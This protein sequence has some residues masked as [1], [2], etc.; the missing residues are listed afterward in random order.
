MDGDRAPLAE[1]CVVA[2]AHDAMLMV[3]EAHAT[4]VL[5]A[6][7]GGL[8]EGLGV[9]EQVTAQIGTLGRHSGARGRSSPA[10]D[11]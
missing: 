6:S 3:D 4:G 10:A 8:V 9:G 5:G 11:P 1:L 7:G 2:A